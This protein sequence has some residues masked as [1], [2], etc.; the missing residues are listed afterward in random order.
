M[1]TTTHLALEIDWSDPDTLVAVAGAVLGLG[2]GIG[3]PLF[4][5]SRDNLDEERLQE[6]REI[7]RQH[8]KE[9]G[10][11]LSEEELKAIRQP[12][13]TDRREFVDDD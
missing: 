8:F 12:R 5:I 10:E 7:N 3:A 2:L 1:A 11:Y 4:Y 6:L 9:T 13:W